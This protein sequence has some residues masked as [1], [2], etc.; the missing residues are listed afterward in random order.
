MGKDLSSFLEQIRSAEPIVAVE[1][2][3]NPADFEVT[4]LLR[5]LEERALFP[6]VIFNHCRNIKGEASPLRVISNVFATRERCALALDLPAG[7]TGFKLSSR[8]AE[9][10]KRLIEPEVV[11]IKQAPVKEVVRKG[12]GLDLGDYP[13]VRH[14]EM[15]PAPYIDMVICLKGRGQPFYNTSFQRN[16]YK[17]PRKLGLFMAARHNWEICRTYEEHGEPAPVIII[18]GHHPAFYLGSLNIQPYGVDD[19]KVIGGIMNEP[20]TLVESE[21]WGKDFLVPAD[22]EVVIEGEVLPGVK[23]AEAPFGEWP[24]YYGPQRLSHVIDVKA[25]THRQNALWQDVFVSHRENWILGGIPK[26]GEIFEAIR[27]YVPTVRSVHLP[28]SGNCRLI[29]YV[30][31]DKQEDGDA[32]Q[33]A[34]IA[35]AICDFIKYVVVVDGDVDPF[36]EGEV[37][38]AMATRC[39]PHEDTDIVKCVKSSPLDPS[40]PGQSE[41]SKMI[42]DATVPKRKAFAQRTKVPQ[43][44]LDRICLE[45][46]LD[47]DTILSLPKYTD[48]LRSS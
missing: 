1:Q 43:R 15:D 33:A 7:E 44:V 41:G 2:E 31:L 38:W 34:L 37:L 28:F 24:G 27:S 23:E 46:Y 17:G 42:I 8:Y 12:A 47:E 25:V 13:L 16:M 26:E 10:T 39:Q 14:H 21:T 36:N 32:R 9:R 22:A 19:Y 11:A 40:I 6:P 3:V 20:L 35:L 4:A 29:C 45:D 48:S 18:L 30:S 5:R